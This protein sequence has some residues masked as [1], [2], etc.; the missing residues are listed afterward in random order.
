MTDFSAR[1]TA[2]SA[3]SGR[4]RTSGRLWVHPVVSPRYYRFYLDG[5]EAVYG[6][7]PTLRT[8]GFPELRDPK[9]GMAV[10]LPDGLRLFIAAN[11]FAVVDPGVVAWADVVGQVNVDPAT[12]Y[13]PKVIPIG[14]SFGLPWRS[15]PS[16]ASFVLRS[17]AMAA[18]SRVPAMLRDYLRANGD[19]APLSEFRPSL[20]T[21]SEVFFIA[22]YWNNA[23]AANE[24]RL[25]FVRAVRRRPSLTLSGGF[26]SREDLPAGYAP[27]RLET[28][29]AHREYLR[30][31][32]ESAFVFNTPA[33]HDC[34]G[35]KLGEFLALGK[36]I[37]STPLERTM[38]GDFRSGEQAHIVDGS[39]ESILAAIDLL[40]ED[41]AYRRH[42]EESARRYWEQ[43]LR[44][45]VVI[46]RMVHSAGGPG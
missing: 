20:S 42:L 9:E 25:R 10:I 3:S 27:F 6:R 17:G 16:L 12:S 30:R 28:P 40:C 31:T 14:P 21:D 19:R 15:R 39:E 22:N 35:W 7:T 38:P 23:P 45:V 36:A 13:S 29:I 24:R 5:L 32:K 2:G 18:P 11:D 34:L 26:R 44:P 43:Y 46:R 4:R 37:I 33:V 8:R 41:R 1:S